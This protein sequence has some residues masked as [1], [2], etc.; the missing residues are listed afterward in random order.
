MREGKR[1]IVF[2]GATREVVPVYDDVSAWT[3]QH[4]TTVAHLLYIEHVCV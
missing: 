2:A 3:M 1:S 4:S